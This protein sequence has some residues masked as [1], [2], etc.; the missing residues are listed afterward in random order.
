MQQIGCLRVA[1]ANRLFESCEIE[2]E[3]CKQQSE[4]GYMQAAKRI[5]QLKGPK[6]KIEMPPT[7][8]RQI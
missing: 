4:N 6:G 1:A 3:I 7:G 5:T 8:G 2:M